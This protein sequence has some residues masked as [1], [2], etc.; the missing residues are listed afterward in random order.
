MKGLAIAGQ[1]L[2]VDGIE[3]EKLVLHQR[4]DDRPL[5]LFDGDPDGA[6]P[7]PLAQL[8]HPVVQ[9]VGALRELEFLDRPAA[10]RLQLH[11]VLLVAPIEAEIRCQ[12]LVVPHR[13][14]LG[15]GRAR[16][17]RS[18]ASPIVES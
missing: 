9:Y 5:A 17:A 14:L 4:V 10:G 16:L 1:R 2:G 3:D 6:P 7:K 18:G 8:R 12:F 13:S 15:E 11:A